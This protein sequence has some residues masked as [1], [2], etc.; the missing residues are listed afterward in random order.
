MDLILQETPPIDYLVI[1]QNQSSLTPLI[2]DFA[3]L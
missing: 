1:S 3:I 2:F